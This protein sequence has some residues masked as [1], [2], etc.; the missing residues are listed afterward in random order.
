DGLPERLGS[1]KNVIT[2]MIEECQ[3]RDIH[4]IAFA[5]DLTH[6]KSIIHTTAQDIMLGIFQ[7][8]QYQD[9]RF[10]VIDGNHDLSGKGSESVS[11]LKSLDTIHNVEWISHQ[12]KGT[13]IHHI[14][15]GR[16][17]FIPYFPGME[18]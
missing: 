4:D 3:K 11:S 15:D 7:Q 8:R 9:L 12:S 17:A 18:K 1:L 2:G 14:D 13:A 6:N 10:Y 16:V 5:G